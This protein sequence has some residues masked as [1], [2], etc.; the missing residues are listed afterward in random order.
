MIKL[1]IQITNRDEENFSFCPLRNVS[2]RIESHTEESDLVTV[3]GPVIALPILRTQSTLLLNHHQLRIPTDSDSLL[4]WSSVLMSIFWCIFVC[5]VYVYRNVCCPALLCPRTFIKIHNWLGSEGLDAWRIPGQRHVIAGCP[6]F[7]SLWE[8]ELVI[9]DGK[10]ITRSSVYAL[11]KIMKRWE[12][13]S[14]EAVTHPGTLRPQLLL[15]R[16]PES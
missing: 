4:P 11:H 9:P 6:F 2:L 10:R 7:S 1:S 3:P 13:W 12:M 8:S 16:S 5:F 15:R 14:K